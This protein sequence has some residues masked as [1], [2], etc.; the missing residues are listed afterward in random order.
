MESG[1]VTLIKIVS[2]LVLAIGII[3]LVFLFSQGDKDE[4]R[5]FNSDH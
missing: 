2:T 3:P 4:P 1:I 5:G